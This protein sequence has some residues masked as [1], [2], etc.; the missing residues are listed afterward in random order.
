M[1]DCEGSECLWRQRVRVAA[2]SNCLGAML[3]VKYIDHDLNIENAD[4]D[5]MGNDQ[6]EAWFRTEI[7]DSMCEGTLIAPG[8]GR[9]ATVAFDP[10][11]EVFIGDSDSQTRSEDIRPV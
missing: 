3:G 4:S 1:P 6:V 10:D 5:Q 2:I 8:D 9:G 7:E 11:V